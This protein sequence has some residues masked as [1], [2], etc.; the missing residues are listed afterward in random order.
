VGWDKPSR[1]NGLKD[2]NKGVKIEVV[3]RDELANLV[4]AAIETAAHTGLKR[5]RKIYIGNIEES[6]RISTGERSENAI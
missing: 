1:K 3:S 5:D 6:V 4:I 2:F